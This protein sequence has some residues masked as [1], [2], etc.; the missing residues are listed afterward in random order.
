MPGGV[1]RHNEQLRR[2][3]DLCAAFHVPI[4]SFV[5]QPGFAVGIQAETEAY[6]RSLARTRG[7]ANRSTLGVDPRKRSTGLCELTE[8]V[9]AHMLSTIRHGAAAMAALYQA[10]VPWYADA[11][12]G[13]R[14]SVGSGLRL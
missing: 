14:Q 4:L 13:H 6:V 11:N 1:D 5:D 12:D 9:C 8:L 2:H 3:V 10:T 7:T